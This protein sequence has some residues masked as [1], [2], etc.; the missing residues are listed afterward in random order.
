M[1]STTEAVKAI[2]ESFRAEARTTE[3]LADGS[4]RRS[5][6]KGKVKAFRKSLRADEKEELKSLRLDT[7]YDD[8]VDRFYENKLDLDSM[9]R[10]ARVYETGIYETP[11]ILENNERGIEPEEYEAIE[12]LRMDYIHGKHKGAANNYMKR[13]RFYVNNK[14]YDDYES[15]MAYAKANYK[16]VD[17]LE[18]YNMRRPEVLERKNIRIPRSEEDLNKEL[19]RIET[20]EKQVEEFEESVTDAQIWKW[21]LK[22]RLGFFTERNLP[23][24]NNNDWLQAKVT[25]FRFEASKRFQPNLKKKGEDSKERI[26]R[27]KIQDDLQAEKLKDSETHPVFTD[28]DAEKWCKSGPNK[29][30]E[31][32]NYVD[33]EEAER[34]ARIWRFIRIGK[35]LEPIEKYLAERE[36]K[37]GCDNDEL[38]LLDDDEIAFYNWCF[39]KQKK[40]VKEEEN[41]MRDLVRLWD[42]SKL[43]KGAE[44]HHDGESQEQSGENIDHAIEVLGQN[45]DKSQQRHGLRK[46]VLKMVVQDDELMEEVR[47]ALDHMRADFREFHDNKDCTSD[48]QKLL[49][50]LQS[51]IDVYNKLSKNPLDHG[52]QNVF[53]QVQLSDDM[54]L[55]FTDVIGDVRLQDLTDVLEIAP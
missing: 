2:K 9:S 15:S 1:S 26:C 5:I 48:D 14:Q 52:C 37:V 10:M 29:Y 22:Q 31:S 6:V 39:D 53:D 28:E 12:R 36:F 23:K 41:V 19:A 51:V 42:Q 27:T 43:T 47:H 45:L 50:D 54:G 24:H 13:P 33:V 18:W 7:F 17:N 49:E 30:G 25:A 38:R 11:E 20:L 8:K 44:D 32:I 16:K 4:T 46:K 3:M 40:N 21:H 34:A 35:M 55:S